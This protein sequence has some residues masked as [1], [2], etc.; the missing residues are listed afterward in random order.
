[1]QV[2][3]L[4]DDHAVAVGGLRDLHAVGPVAS[5][6]P[7]ATKTFGRQ[8]AR[9]LLD[10]AGHVADAG[11]RGAPAGVGEAAILQAG[12]AL[13]EFGTAA[14]GG[15]RAGVGEAAILRAGAARDEFGPAALRPGLRALHV[16]APAR[17]E[18]TADA[19]AP[20]PTT[21]AVVGAR[22]R[23]RGRQRGSAA[24]EAV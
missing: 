14:R 22:G 20:G 8:V 24:H 2:G 19:A 12:D 11:R 17:A 7:R 6:A 15:R 4:A 9:R 16:V 10:V 5:L 23:L 3:H 18:G 13:D 21:A 1:H